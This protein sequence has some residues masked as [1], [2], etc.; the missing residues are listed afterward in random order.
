M[1]STMNFLSEHGLLEYSALAEKT[2]A[3]T[4]RYNELSA[5]I[6]A[7][8]SRMAEISVLQT[9]IRNYS[10]TRQ[11]YADYREAGYSKKFL[12]EHE[13]EILLHKAAKKAFDELSLK[14]LPTIRE[15][16]AEYAQLLTEKKTDYDEY[17]QARDDMR[18]L[19]AV[20]ANVDHLMGREEQRD[21]NEQEHGQR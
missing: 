20:K 10:D 18:E 17:R 12:A 3:A 5:K 2:T 13:A 4:A 16:Q 7:A 14:K 6:K 21:E 9:H 15:L 11:V 8:E 1:A 19:L